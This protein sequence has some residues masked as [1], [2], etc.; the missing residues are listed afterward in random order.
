MDVT[1]L[2]EWHRVLQTQDLTVDETDATLKSSEGI[3]V[4]IDVANT[5][6]TEWLYLKLYDAAS[7]TV[8]SAVPTY[9][10]ALEPNT[11]RTIQLIRPLKFD[12]AIHYAATTERGAG[13]TGPA[14]DPSVHFRYV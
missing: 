11:S 5:H 3:I 14:T 4:E 1:L 2:P 9:S 8:S 7:V 6:A 10:Y 12:T 13:D